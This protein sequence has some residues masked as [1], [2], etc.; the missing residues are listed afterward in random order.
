MDTL[1]S[2]LRTIRRETKSRQSHLT[3]FR[4]FLGHLDRL[5]RRAAKPP[6]PKRKPRGK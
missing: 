6:P 1:H 2:M 4:E 3:V 5:G